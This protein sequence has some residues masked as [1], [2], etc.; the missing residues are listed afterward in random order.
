MSWLPQRISLKT[1]F[2]VTT[3]GVLLALM[4]I[5]ILLVSN[6]FT[7]SIREEAQARGLA[8]AHNIAAVSTNALLTYNYIAL[9]QN[10]EKASQGS[11]IAYVIILNKE[12]ITKICICAFL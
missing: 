10:A 1:R 4:V 9:E 8:V 2:M 3:S 12:M 7:K 6:R 11:D 5:I